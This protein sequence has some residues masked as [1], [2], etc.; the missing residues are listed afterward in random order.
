V[1]LEN[2][3][4]RSLK[5]SQAHIAAGTD[6]IRRFA[7]GF[8]P[9]VGYADTANPD[10]ASLAPFCTAGERFYC[11]EW[12]GAE[13]PGW[14]IE[15]DTTM[16][17]MLWSGTPP[18][19]AG[20]AAAVRL[21]LEHVPQMTVLAALTKPG[22]FADRPMEIGEWYG[23]LDGDRVVAI[24]GERLHEGKFRE[25]SGVCTLPEYQGRGYARLLTE[26]ILLSQLARGLMPFL[27]VASANARARTLY[28]RMG[29]V[30]EREVP[31][32]IVFFSAR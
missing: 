31:M 9:L 12:R 32:R 5:G 15:V 8:P 28:E 18:D 25:I 1:T 3:I 11:A 21:G 27:H 19:P 6:S 22:P 20:S 4:W 17:A 30:V 29:F 10:F 23:V 26:K 13:P 7:P 14:K 24:A 16:C 2:I